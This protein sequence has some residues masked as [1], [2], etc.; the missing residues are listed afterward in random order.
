MSKNKIDE[1]KRSSVLIIDDEPNNITVLSDILSRDY[2]VCAVI[3]SIDAIET[4]EADMPDVILLD[5]IMPEVDGYEII[6]KLKSSEKTCNIPVIFITGLDSVDAEEKGLAL[7]AADYITK[8]FHAQIVRMRVKNQIDIIERYAIE[9]NLNTVLKLQS[10]LVAAREE[11]EKNR[12]IAERSKEAADYANRAKTD[13]LARMSHEM[14]TPMNAIMG[15][16]SIIKMRGVPETQKEF[17][18]EI[19]IASEQL[20]K[21]IDDVLDISSAEKGAFTLKNEEF[22]FELMIQDVIKTINLTVA[23]KNQR[24]SINITPSLKTTFSGDERHLKR[25][26]LSLLDNAVKF[27]PDNGEIHFDA[28]IINE[29]D[30]KIIL[31]VEISDNGIGIEEDKISKL[32]ELFEQGDGSYTRKH[33]GIGV[34]LALSKRIVEQMDGEIW[35]ESVEGKGTKAG[36]RCKLI[37]ISE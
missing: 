31:Q 35:I 15:M 26:I 4:V 16:M 22:G 5:I 14:R 23:E 3:D 17:Y 10:E 7:G 24:L 18:D 37:R 30:K 6:R 1:N 33:G 27:T 28:R 13:F 36:F 34:G 25:V 8:P 12:E 2:T 29:E 11:A 32:F 9:R 19:N 20:L 21:L